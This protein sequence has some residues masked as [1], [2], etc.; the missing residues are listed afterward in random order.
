MTTASEIIRRA[1]REGN[2][3]A[4]GATLSDAD[5]SEG[6]ALLQSIVDTLFPLVVGSNPKPWYVPVPQ[7]TSTVAHNYPALPGGLSQQERYD[8]RFPPPTSRLL[9]RATAPQTI[10]FQYQPQDGALMEFVDI[11]HTA[12]ITLDANGALFGTT[13]GDSTVVI[14]ADPDARNAPRRWVYREDYGSWVEITTLALT[15]DMPFPTSFDDFFITELAMRLTP[16]NGN[17]PRQ[18]TVMRN[19]EMKSFIRNLY[20]QMAEG[21]YNKPGG[22]TTAKTYYDGGGNSDFNSGR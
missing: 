8:V 4:K 18:V 16:S 10:Y 6:L 15:S 9:V 3:I 2:F 1:Y 20:V 14:P 5:G 21:W 7:R 12:T 13:G 19:R 17:E 11:G 22:N